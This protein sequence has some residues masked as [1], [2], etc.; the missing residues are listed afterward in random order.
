MASNR[1]RV[2]AALAGS[3]LA[4]SAFTAGWP[5]HAQDFS[6]P[7]NAP[8]TDPNA[9][10]L[11]SALTPRI[12][13][14]WPQAAPKGLDPLAFD[15]GD[16]TAPCPSD[17]GTQ[18]FFG[19]GL[20]ECSHTTARFDISS[21]TGLGQLKVS[22]LTVT[23]YNA[24]DVA[25]HSA[26]GP[27]AGKITDGVFAPDGTSWNHPSYTVVLPL[28]GVGSALTVDLGTV[29]TICGSASCGGPP[30]VQGDRH[31]FQFEYY[32]GTTWITWGSVPEVSGNG[33]HSRQ[34]TKDPKYTGPTN[35]ST[36]YVRLWA[37]PG[38]DDSNFSISEVQLKD[39]AGNIVSTGKLAIGPRPYQITDGVVA[40]EGTAWN[41]TTHAIVLR[42]DGPAHALAIDLGAPVNVSGGATCDPSDLPGPVIQADKNEYQF[43]YSLDG[44][45]W[46]PY[47]QLPAVT[48]AGLRTRS[49]QPIVAGHSNPD[50]TARYVR[51][52][53]L[54]GDG[55]YSISEVSL[56]NPTCTK[57]SLGALTYGPEPLATDGEI[58]P[59]GTDW[60]DP[61]YAAILSPCPSGST[62]PEGW[63]GSQASK[64]GG[65]VI[66]LTASFPIASVA[67][68]ADRH[69]FQIDYWDEASST[70][71][72]L[73]TVADVNGG[74]GLLTR[75]PCTFTAPLPVARRLL[76]YGTAG[77]D[78]NYSVSSIQVL[79]STAKT[80][81][82]SASS[83]D[84][85]Q[86]F[87]CTYDGRFSTQLTPPLGGL[88][89]AFTVDSAV[90]YL[91]CT[92]GTS[93]G[94]TP[95]K[96]IIPSG[97]TCQATLTAPSPTGGEFCSASCASTPSQSVLSLVQLDGLAAGA[98]EISDVVCD[99]SLD[100]DVK[101]G[102][103]QAVQGGAALAVQ[104][105]F[106]ALVV[107]P[108]AGPM[109][110]TGVCAAPGAE[111]VPDTAFKVQGRASNVGNA[112]DNG[113]VWIRGRFT[114]HDAIPLNE[115]RL[116]LAA[117]LEETGGPR[118][119]VRGAGGTEF[120]P[121]QLLPRRGNRR[122]SASFQTPAG[123][124]P[125]VRVDVK[126]LDVNAGLMEFAMRVDR[127]AIVAPP[128]CAGGTARAQLATHFT[129]HRIGGSV[130]GETPVDVHADSEWQCRGR[131]LWRP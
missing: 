102:L 42:K 117:L 107:N 80:A 19:A 21:Y 55:N 64:T 67:V 82:A 62:C 24:K 31:A 28:Q 75:P 123:A 109:V 126:V 60:N 10:G 52:W 51:V 114:S 83:A 9:S 17:G 23:G 111:P 108:S 38:A 26:R 106:N 118:E 87:S 35:F 121:L 130:L 63:P 40:K 7:V 73:C 61:R 3:V 6:C 93:D 8:G 120:L 15:T 105:F 85:G 131:E 39:T 44:V 1:S 98:L 96:T 127:T 53:G 22:N 119:L 14:V 27:D 124:R 30:W 34:V 72:A 100:S 50:F 101:N 18:C 37:S 57:I 122:T 84:A 36:Q 113:S 71:K 99:A 95:T 89:V 12:N 49:L 45:N 77:D 29:L 16:V 13:A 54:S 48:G 74:S 32:N 20:P 65:L 103:T 58:A 128:S 56:Y 86:A 92:N 97:T 88:T 76:V 116:T 46:V 66:D 94:S 2:V 81:C 125:I 90:A 47:S 69:R 25:T 41:D 4:V 112:K 104:E 110:P 129:L 59:S 91:R 33:L 70:W 78:S 11:L 43:D 79:T 5:A 115:A 68:Q